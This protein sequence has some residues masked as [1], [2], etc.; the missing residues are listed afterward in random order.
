MRTICIIQARVGSTRFPGK[1]LA[2]L[3]GKPM[4]QHIIDRCGR[5]MRVDQ[6]VVV[7][8]NT[9]ENEVLFDFASESVRVLAPDC[10]ESDLIGRHWFAADLLKPDAIVRVPADNP[11]VEPAEISHAVRRYYE[12]RSKTAIPDR[13]MTNIQPLRGN[14][15]PDGI[16][17]EVYGFETLRWM[18]ETITDKLLREHPHKY[19]M[20]SG[21]YYTLRCPAGIKRPDLRL[22]VNTKADLAFIRDIYDALYSQTPNFTTVDILR[23]LDG[24]SANA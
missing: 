16:G 2:D 8:P 18:H 17:C 1:V 15:Y 24:R 10:D 21:F 23:Y 7:I 6:V 20:D 5:A 13:M 19:F 12:R 9:A 4:L 22:D 3:A 14:G 11:C